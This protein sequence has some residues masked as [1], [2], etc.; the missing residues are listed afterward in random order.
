MSYL[1]IFFC[2]ARTKSVSTTSIAVTGSLI[3]YRCRIDVVTCFLMPSASLVNTVLN[4]LMFFCIGVI[5]FLEK[6][7]LR[8]FEYFS[9]QNE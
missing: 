7:F 9:V 1:L 5:L 2:S 8:S 6:V 3:T 4:I